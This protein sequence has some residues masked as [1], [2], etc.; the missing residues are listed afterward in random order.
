FITVNVILAK[1]KYGKIDAMITTAMG[2]RGLACAVLATVPVQKGI[3]G[4][5][6]VQ[7]TIFAL[8]PMTIIF[9]AIF[10]V[11]AENDKFRQRINHLFGGYSDSTKEDKPVGAVPQE[12]QV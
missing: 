10:V 1:Q 8:I 3:V 4:G 11:L 9:T 2:P 5:A 6:W 12:S 7:D